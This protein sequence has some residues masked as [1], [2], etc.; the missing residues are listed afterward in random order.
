M[1]T[2]RTCAHVCV[3]GELRSRDDESNGAKIRTYEIVAS[4]IINLR[5]GQ[6]NAAPSFLASLIKK[7]SPHSGRAVSRLQ[8]ADTKSGERPN[9]H[10][11]IAPGY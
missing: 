4:A 6:R 5:A 3:E 8:T 9:R 7:R 2:S 11:T 1:T 10:R